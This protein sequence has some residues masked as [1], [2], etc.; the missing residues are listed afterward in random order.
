MSVRFV[1]GLPTGLQYTPIQVG[2]W[3][4]NAP[5]YLRVSRTGSLWVTQYS[6]DGSTWQG[7]GSFTSTMVP[8][9]VGV[10]CGSSTGEARPQTVRVDWFESAVLPIQVEDPAPG[11]DT[12]A[13]FVY[14]V[15]AVALSETA[16]QISWAT[17]EP[18]TGRVEWGTSSAYG[19]APEYGGALAMRHTVTLLGLNPATTYHFQV[20]AEDGL[21]NSGSTADQTVDTLAPLGLNAP[22][23][24]FWYGDVDPVTGAHQLSFG[25][26]GNAQ[27][28]FNVLGRV[29]D[30]DQDRIALEVTLECR[31]NGGP[32]QLMALGDDRTIN[33]APWRLANEGDFNLELFVDSLLGTPL[34]GGV[35]RS[36]LEFRAIDDALN[37]TRA[38]VLVDYTPDVTWLD[39][40]TVSWADVV[41]NLAGRVDQA[42]QIVDGMWEVFNDPVLGQVL[43]PDPAELGYDR[44]IAIGEAHGVDA[45]ENYEALLPVTVESF[46]PQGYTTGTSSYGMGF[47]MRWT[48]HTEGGPYVQPNHGLYPLGGLYL[49]RWF[50]SSERW[51]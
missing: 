49:Y 36:T 51:E 24:Q 45:W 40:L 23:I 8:T 42:V 34:V 11:P 47:G 31:W 38:T 18:S 50:N 16:I 41:N 48:G 9:S 33:F 29:I 2:A 35:H 4:T 37:E 12:V 7:V 6:F 10:M 14:D 25:E 43:R 44:L 1:N 5:L 17:E 20:V 28:Q 19:M 13:P 26:L 27:N 39:T 30:A 32:W 15:D 22:E 3:A 46:D 21:M